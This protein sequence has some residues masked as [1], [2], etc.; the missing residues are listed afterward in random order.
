VFY[1]RTTQAVYLTT[2]CG[3]DWTRVF[4]FPQPALAVAAL[5]PV[6]RATE[7]AAFH[8]L[9]VGLNDWRLAASTVFGTDSVTFT[10]DGSHWQGPFQVSGTGP[11]QVGGLGWGQPLG[12]WRW[13]LQR[14]HGCL[15]IHYAVICMHRPAHI[16]AVVYE[17]IWTRLLSI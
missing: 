6:S 5:R 14:T 12:M 7:A 16:S 4:D 10:T 8:A 17:A 2:N 3:L 1:T 11:G 13:C 15:T 9:G